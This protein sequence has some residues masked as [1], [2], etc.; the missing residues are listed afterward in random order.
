LRG[1]AFQAGYPG[2]I[3]VTR[4]ATQGPF[5]QVQAV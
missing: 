2:S 5:R 4:G 1:A 3:P